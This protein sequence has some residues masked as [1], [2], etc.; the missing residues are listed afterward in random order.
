MII[1]NSGITHTLKIVCPN[2]GHENIITYTVYSGTIIT[3]TSTTC[4]NCGEIIK[5]EE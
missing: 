4:K 1:D 2:C 5:M 3:I